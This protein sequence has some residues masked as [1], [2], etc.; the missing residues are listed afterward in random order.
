M[1][2]STAGN[3]QSVSSDAVQAADYQSPVCSILLTPISGDQSQLSEAGALSEQPVA[4]P[5]AFST[6]MANN[7]GLPDY[8][9]EWERQT[10][11]LQQD[12]FA[13][14]DV[15]TNAD[16]LGIS[17]NVFGSDRMEMVRTFGVAAN[18]SAFPLQVE[19]MDVV[20]PGNNVRAFTVPEISWEPVLNTAPHVLPGTHPVARR[21]RRSSCPIIIRTMAARPAFS[22]TVSGWFRWRPSR[23]ASS[24]WTNLSVRS[25]ILP[26]RCL[27]CPSGCAPWQ[28]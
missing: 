8:Q 16:L 26:L 11:C 13:L 23:S 9:A 4:T 27:P 21:G 20:S 25:L 17:F 10:P 1:V 5:P 15:S 22:I 12:L 6:E 14:L 7:L 2:G 3:L 18:S 24:S 19:G 28:P